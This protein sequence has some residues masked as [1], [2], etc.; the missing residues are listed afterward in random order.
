MKLV[1]MPVI[2]TKMNGVGCDVVEAATSDLTLEYP[3]EASRVLQKRYDM[4]CAL[5]GRVIIDLPFLVE[6]SR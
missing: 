2:L 6:C 5:R 4:P 1:V 3:V